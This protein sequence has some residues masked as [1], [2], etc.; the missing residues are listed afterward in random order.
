[1]ESKANEC[2]NDFQ[3]LIQYGDMV[4]ERD[5]HT[6]ARAHKGKREHNNLFE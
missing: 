6:R 4:N 5:T 1:M 2:N 3:V